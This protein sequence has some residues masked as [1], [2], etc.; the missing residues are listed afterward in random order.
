MEYY[1]KLALCLLLLIF[2]VIALYYSKEISKK[3]DISKRNKVINILTA[4][5]FVVSIISLAIIYL[6]K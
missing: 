3:V 4:T 1:T 5:G 6:L 2:G